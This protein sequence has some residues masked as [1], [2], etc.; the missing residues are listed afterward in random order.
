MLDI[1]TFLFEGG[2]GVFVVVVVLLALLARAQAG[3]SASDKGRST[4]GSI[5]LNSI[6]TCK[7]DVRNGVDNTLGEGG[8]GGVVWRYVPSPTEMSSYESLLETKTLANPLLGTS[9]R[10]LKWGR[11]K[12]LSW[13]LPADHPRQNRS[14]C[15]ALSAEA[16]SDSA[17]HKFYEAARRRVNEFHIYETVNALID[18]K[19][20]LGLPCGYIQSH[21]SCETHYR[22]IGKK[23][24]TTCY[25]ELAE[26]RLK[27]DD[28]FLQP[29]KHA[30]KLPGC[31]K[32]PLRN[33][34]VD[35]P[36]RWRVH[37]QVF[38]ITGGW[39]NK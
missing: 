9:K 29:E 21:E 32:P 3:R 25:R 34:S 31:L 22:F 11:V 27:W 26:A 4:E 8:G 18:E 5:E 2:H 1:S 36:W 15:V 38:M 16:G 12:Q 10:T 20:V 14:R 35:A 28:M 19:G 23:W 39:D 17:Y 24:S 37:E 6:G 13:Q 7:W 33:A 30:A